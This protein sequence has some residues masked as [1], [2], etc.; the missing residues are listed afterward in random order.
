M[1]LMPQIADLLANI[2]ISAFRGL[3]GAFSGPQQLFL[4]L[5]LLSIFLYGMSVGKTRALV[6]LLCIYVAFMLSAAFPFMEWLQGL[7]K[8]DIDPGVVRTGLFFAFYLF[9]FAAL[10][11]SSL[12]GRLSVGEM[13]LWQVFLVSV[14]QI[15]FLLSI[16]ASFLPE[17]LVT[18][19]VQQIYPYVST[20]KALFFWAA[21]SVAILPLIKGRREHL[22]A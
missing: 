10:N 6:S 12:R 2:D 1:I 7:I 3:L 19:N 13:S 18:K 22:L 15:G 17:E 14:F 11:H 9:V 16:V 8:T 5:V 20:P 4:A 21:A